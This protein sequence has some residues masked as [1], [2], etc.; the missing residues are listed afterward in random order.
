MQSRI[1]PRFQGGEDLWLGWGRWFSWL[2]GRSHTLVLTS[3]KISNE[4]DK[5]RPRF[6]DL[7]NIINNIINNNNKNNKKKKKKS[8]SGFFFAYEFSLWVFQR[9]EVKQLRSHWTA[10]RCMAMHRLWAQE[11]SVSEHQPWPPEDAPRRTH[12]TSWDTWK[13]QKKPDTFLR[14]V[15]DVQILTH[16]NSMWNNLVKSVHLPGLQ[17]NWW[18][19]GSL[20]SNCFEDPVW[21]GKEVEGLRGQN[22]ILDRFR[23]NRSSSNSTFLIFFFDVMSDVFQKVIGSD[24]HAP[25]PDSSPSGSDPKQRRGAD[26]EEGGP[27]F[28]ARFFNTNFQKVKLYFVSPTLDIWSKFQI[29]ILFLK[30]MWFLGNSVVFLNAP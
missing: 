22:F 9:V 28:S 12:E 13:K 15:G 2:H 5:M 24:I 6:V 26:L 20:L 19:L 23:W 17:K 27:T 14:F 29:F 16:V 8:L 10:M 30:R 21:K 25:F 4:S 11:V 18:V 7:N 1:C 3:F